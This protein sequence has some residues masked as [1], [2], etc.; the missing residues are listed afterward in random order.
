MSSLR[1]KVILQR[2][3]N[4][5]KTEMFLLWTKD[6]KIDNIVWLTEYNKGVICARRS[7]FQ[8]WQ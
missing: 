1:T 8:R 4:E 6:H 7:K 3:L 2:T 5:V